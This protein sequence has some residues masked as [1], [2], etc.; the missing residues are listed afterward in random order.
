[1]AKAVTQVFENPPIAKEFLPLD[2]FSFKY[3]TTDYLKHELM[4]ATN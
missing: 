2:F 1:M 4:D 3:C